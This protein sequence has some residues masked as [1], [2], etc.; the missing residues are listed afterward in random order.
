MFEGFERARIDTGDATINV[1]H[2]GSGPP[3]LLLHGFPQTSAMWAG[4]APEL[5][6]DAHRRRHRP[7]RLRA[8]PRARSPGP[9]TPAT[10]SAPWPPTRSR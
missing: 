8:S 9:T 6:D 7:A 3:V 2:G 4:I 5:A 1:V 10:R